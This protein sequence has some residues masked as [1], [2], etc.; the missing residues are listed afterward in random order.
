MGDLHLAMV[1]VLQ[2]GDQLR[3]AHL[4]QDDDGVV[5]RVVLQREAQRVISPA[6]HAAI[7]S[8]VPQEME[9]CLTLGNIHTKNRM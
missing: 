6:L 9:Q 3:V 8:R 4:V 7:S 1:H 2:E 5:A